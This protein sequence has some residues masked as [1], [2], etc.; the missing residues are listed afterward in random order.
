[1]KLVLFA[2]SWSPKSGGINA[3]NA[4][5]AAALASLI[6]KRGSVHC[7]VP[8]GDDTC[9]SAARRQG[10][11]LVP[12]PSAAGSEGFGPEIVGQVRE[13]LGQAAER[14]DYWI[15]HDVVTGDAAIECAAALGGKSALIHHMSY[16]Q[17]Q[18]LKSEDSQDANKKHLRQAALFRKS[19][20]VFGVGPALAKAAKT[21][22]SQDATE[23]IPGFPEEA[24]PARSPDDSICAITYG[25]L[26]H[27]SE[28]IKQGELVLQGFIKAMAMAEGDVPVPALKHAQLTLIGVDIKEE[29][30]AAFRQMAEAGVN[31]AVNVQTLPF[32]ES[33]DELFGLLRGFNVGLVLS[34]H[35]GFGL[36]AWEMIASEIP[37]ILSKNSGLYHLVDRELGASG[38][39]CLFA[40]DIRGS[41]EEKPYQDTDVQVVARELIKIAQDIPGAKKRAAQLKKNLEE[42]IGATWEQTARSFLSTLGFDVVGLKEASTKS[43]QL[44]GAAAIDWKAAAN[45]WFLP[46]NPINAIPD[47]AGLA[48]DTG[49]GSNHQEYD[50]LAQVRFGQYE[51]EVEGV[52]V[53]Y[54]LKRADMHLILDGCAIGLGKRLG[55][56]PGEGNIKAHG[57][58]KWEIGDALAD[59]PMSGTMVGPDLLCKVKKTGNRDQFVQLKLSCFRRDIKIDVQP[60]DGELAPDQKKILEIFLAKCIGGKPDEDG[61]LTLST[62]SATVKDPT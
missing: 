24:H 58:A 3:F 7:V 53:S 52:F 18:V 56:D 11:T 25:R 54:G 37:L 45:G 9:A 5:F 39:A 12:A 32:T 13:A 46:D 59:V 35:E 48:I 36:A 8:E 62:A 43:E 49:Q 57:Q 14:I 61:R 15:G 41:F 29:R 34:L 10:V 1:L 50:L 19:D 26:D 22:G 16:K 30:E 55:D 27:A 31:R 17:Y 21:L 28:R 60:M 20:V 40:V 2:T 33:R 6:G 51:R 44:A 47:C 38:V 42:R 23:L 4:P